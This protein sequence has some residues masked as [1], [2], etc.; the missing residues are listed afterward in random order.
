MLDSG[1]AEARSLSKRPFMWGPAR[2][3]KQGP[4]EEAPT[5]IAIAWWY[6]MTGCSRLPTVANLCPCW[7][8]QVV[9]GQKQM[10]GA[11]VRICRTIGTGA[12]RNLDP[13]LMLVSNRPDCVDHNMRCLAPGT[14]Q[15]VQLLQCHSCLFVAG[16]QERVGCSIRN[17]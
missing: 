10:E 7:V 11:G 14:I 8:P 16:Q 9:Q 6:S 17:Q 12:L 3:H 13:F 2:L 4:S 5:P 1:G 15:T